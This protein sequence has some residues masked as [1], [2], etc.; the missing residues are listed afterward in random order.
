[1]FTCTGCGSSSPCCRSAR[2]VRKNT[3]GVAGRP[4]NTLPCSPSSCCMSLA[5][6]WYPLGRFRA[7]LAASLAGIILGGMCFLFGAGLFLLGSLGGAGDV[8]I[9]G[10]M[11]AVISSFIV[12]RS[13]ISY[14]QAN[15]VLAVHA[16]PRH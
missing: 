8:S 5:M 15:A 12:T 14:Q 16:L 2:H 3:S 1:M 13:L 9:G 7:L 10:A 6:R 4:S 11:L